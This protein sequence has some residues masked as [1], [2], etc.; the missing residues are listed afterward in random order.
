[1][2]KRTGKAFAFFYCDAS[3]E[4]IRGD[5]S[6]IMRRAR[7]SLVLILHEGTAQIDK[8]LAE[9]VMSTER[10]AQCLEGERRPLNSLKYVFVAED[11][12]ATNEATNKNTANELRHIMNHVRD[13][14]N[15]SG[16]FRGVI[17]FESNGV[18]HLTH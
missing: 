12:D 8:R 16:L 7:K 2:A 11:R 17:A 15:I 9:G 4:Q 3:K 1:M 18:Y 10:R 13:R 14:Y 5:I 6:K